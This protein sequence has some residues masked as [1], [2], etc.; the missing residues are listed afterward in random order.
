[1]HQLLDKLRDKP[2]DIAPPALIAGYYEYA[3]S[4]N[5]RAV[6]LRVHYEPLQCLHV[7]LY[8]DH[9]K[10]E[11]DVEIRLSLGAQSV[12]FMSL[13]SPKHPGWPCHGRG[14]GTLLANCT[15]AF[16]QAIYPPQAVLTGWAPLMDSP[17]DEDPDR[18]WERRWEFWARFGV[19]LDEYNM[20]DVQIGNLILVDNGKSCL[21]YFPRILPVSA[22]KYA[23]NRARQFRIAGNADGEDMM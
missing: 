12:R 15:I 3:D 9:S 22:F 2:C 10:A 16:L 4:W 21:E 7:E 14:I 20:F 1:M 13:I 11:A 6:Y 17:T 5:D 19:M 18:L 8:I 23:G